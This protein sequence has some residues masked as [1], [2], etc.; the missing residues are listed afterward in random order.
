MRTSHR[1][2][3]HKRICCIF[4]LHHFLDKSGTYISVSYQ[5]MFADL[6]S[7]G[8][9]KNVRLF[10]RYKNVFNF[11]H[12]YCLIVEI[13]LYLLAWKCI[14]L[15]QWF[16]RIS[17]TYWLI[18]FFSNRFIWFS[19]HHNFHDKYNFVFDEIIVLLMNKHF[20]RERWKKKQ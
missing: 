10:Y 8:R 19:S 5:H 4:W 15:L 20:D 11:F 16:R 17:H 12:D 3:R 7:C 13:H 14:C 6:Q 9:Y 18:I 2:L 1:S